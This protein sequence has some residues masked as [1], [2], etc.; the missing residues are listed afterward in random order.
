MFAKGLKDDVV[1]AGTKCTKYTQRS[2]HKLVS[3]ICIVLSKERSVV[4]SIE[5]N[6]FTCQ[7][8]YDPNSVRRVAVRRASSDMIAPS[9]RIVRSAAFRSVSS[10]LNNMTLAHRTAH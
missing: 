3:L 8:L 9:V 1:C 10:T 4:K 5:F 2:S 7:E 6:K